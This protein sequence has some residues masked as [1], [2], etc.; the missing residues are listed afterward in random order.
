VSQLARLG[1]LLGG[2]FILGYGSALASPAAARKWLQSFPR[3]RKT[4]WMLTAI[5]LVWAG[6]LLYEAPLGRFDVVKPFIFVLTPIAVVLV[7]VFVD[8]LLAPR[9]L[10]GLFLLL[11][12]P[13]L[14][15]ARWH[16]SPLRLVVTVL[17]YGMVVKGMVL[18][19]CPYQF[20]KWVERLLSTDGQCRFWSAVGCTLGI[21]VVVLSLTVY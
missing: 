3:S 7:S 14:D 21:V 1:L 9:A 20:R 10:G 11:A 13:M 17:A 15:V 16:V 4:A 12:A 5:D 19:V 18:I 2:L 6:R 8:E